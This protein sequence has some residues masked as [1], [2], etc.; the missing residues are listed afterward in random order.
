MA[1]SLDNNCAWHNCDIIPIILD[2]SGHLPVAAQSFLINGLGYWY[3]SKRLIE[4]DTRD[5]PQ[6]TQVILWIPRN[7]FIG[8]KTFEFQ[9]PVAKAAVTK[10]A[11]TLQTLPEAQITFA[12]VSL[13]WLAKVKETSLK[14]LASVQKAKLSKLQ[15]LILDARKIIRLSGLALNNEDKDEVHFMVKFPKNTELR[16][17]TLS[18]RERGTDGVLGQMNYIFRIRK[19]EISKIGVS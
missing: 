6:G 9:M 18:F 13:S 7:K 1:V 8:L 3:T 17:M 5:L 12:P 2:L 4:I 10:I 19:S 15:P 11:D 16:D 14:E